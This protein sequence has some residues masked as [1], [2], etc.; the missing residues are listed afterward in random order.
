MGQ[1]GG[2]MPTMID[3]P[4]C[5]APN[6]VRRE[7]CFNCG[8]LL[9]RTTECGAT[10]GAP[11][12]TSQLVDGAVMARAALII[13]IAAV[14]ASIIPAFGLPLAVLATALATIALRSRRHGTAIAALTCGIIALV[15]SLANAIWGAVLGYRAA[16][17]AQEALSALRLYAWGRKLC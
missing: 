9:P 12:T 15:L 5:G 11:E 4:G 13:G 10:V 14:P 6:S 7:G 3:C 2:S 8:A 16:K 17:D 1:K